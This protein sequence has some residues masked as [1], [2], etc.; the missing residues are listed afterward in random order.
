MFCSTPKLLLSRTTCIFKWV[1]DKSDDDTEYL[2]LG[3]VLSVA[4]GSTCVVDP[5]SKILVR[6]CPNDK[7]RTWR[8]VLLEDDTFD[9]QYS[10]RL[11]AAPYR[12]LIEK[13]NC[14]V[15]ALNL[16]L[17]ASGNFDNKHRLDD[18]STS[19]EVAKSALEDFY[20]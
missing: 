10:S 3:I 2:W 9:I 17:T 8:T 19:K 14:I 20:A 15:H 4:E 11:R 1:D 12:I 5:H 13:R 7:K 6:W 16:K 18:G